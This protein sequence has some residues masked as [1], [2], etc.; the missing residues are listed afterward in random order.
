MK[1][2]YNVNLKQSFTCSRFYITKLSP[3]PLFCGD[4]EKGDADNEE[5]R[6]RKMCCDNNNKIKCDKK[7]KEGESKNIE[8]T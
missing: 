6:E 3:I 5:K 7:K 8:I 2:N 1:W 4:R